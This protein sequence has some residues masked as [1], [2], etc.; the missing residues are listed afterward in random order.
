M[1]MSR[2]YRF[3][4]IKDRKV[5]G[6]WISMFF[7]SVAP[8]IGAVFPLSA[9]RVGNQSAGLGALARIVAMAMNWALRRVFAPA[10]PRQAFGAVDMPR[11]LITNGALP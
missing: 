2:A 1:L 8:S 3:I 6:T 10:R 9:P 7:R 5:G 11:G 4:S